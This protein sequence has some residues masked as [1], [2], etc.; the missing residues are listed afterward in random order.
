MKA[1]ME[2][3]SPH[4]DFT[5]N[6]RPNIFS[7]IHDLLIQKIKIIF[8]NLVRSSTMLTIRKFKRQKFWGASPSLVVEN[9]DY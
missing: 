2:K 3:T 7:V 8:R 5:L 9:D 6:F 1:L 4:G